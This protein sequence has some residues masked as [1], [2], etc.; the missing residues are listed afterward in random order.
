MWIYRFIPEWIKDHLRIAA[1]RYKFPRCHIATPYIAGNVTLGQ[2]CSLSRG[3]ELGP[4][5]TLGDWSYVNS[6]T[7]I[8]SGRIGRFCSVGSL[9]QIGM[10]NHPM[11]F[12]S[13]SPKLYGPANVF[14]DGQQWDH[15]AEPPEIGSD[16]WIGA[17]AFVRQGV[18]VGSGA[19]IAAGAVVVKDVPA[20][21]VVAGV[22]ARVMRYRFSSQTIGRILENPWWDMPVTSLR[23]FREAFVTPV[24]P[25]AARL[26]S[27]VSGMWNA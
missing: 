2:G 12:L 13:T 18:R 4:G 21:A 26:E 7:L 16:V 5:V 19:V 10:P 17:H 1:A 6:G 23:S 22:P 3:V 8:A 11:D 15:Y 9:C 24:E 20:F 27:A 25:P 14:D